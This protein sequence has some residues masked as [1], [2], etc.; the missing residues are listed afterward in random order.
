MP[1]RN[2]AQPLSILSGLGI[3]TGCMSNSCAWRKDWGPLKIKDVTSVTAWA[4]CPFLRA[5][6][7]PSRC[8]KY[9]CGYAA[10]IDVVLVLL[11]SDLTASDLFMMRPGVDRSVQ[12]ADCD[13]C[14]QHGAG[15]I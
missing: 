14:K 1:C 5:N 6:T 9:L 7:I 8:L 4:H 2:K 10:V 12:S 3:R 11:G 13:I 15:E